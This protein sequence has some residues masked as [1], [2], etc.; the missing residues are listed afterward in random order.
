MGLYIYVYII[1]LLIIS[2]FY[3]IIELEFDMGKTARKDI[4]FKLENLLV[5]FLILP[6]W[7]YTKY[8]SVKAVQIVQ[9]V[10]IAE[11]E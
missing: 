10:Q 9:I 11:I 2:F 5:T 7:F 8:D 3:D 6:F 1:W 4:S